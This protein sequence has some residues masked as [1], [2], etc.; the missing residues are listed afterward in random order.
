MFGGAGQSPF[1]LASPQARTDIP[2]TYLAL[3]QAAAAN[4]AGLSW[5]VLAGI[6]KVESDHGRSR[7][8]G[9]R[10]GS[11]GAGAQ[12]PM[13]FLPATFA[14]YAA[15]PPPGGLDPPSPF[16]PPDAIYAAARMLCANGAHH[17]TDLYAAIWSYN[18]S[19]VYVSNV[20]DHAR[21][22]TTANSGTP[23]ASPGALPGP[24]VG[25][26]ASRPPP[27]PYRTRT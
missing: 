10:Q 16:D 12:G 26:A 23:P 14:R 1:A 6:G 24:R 5:A 25:A 13:Q 4:C 11:N 8:P 9:V 15:P 27:R 18:H 20:L 21:R 22:Y 2:A 17:N 7:L 19:D 3:Y